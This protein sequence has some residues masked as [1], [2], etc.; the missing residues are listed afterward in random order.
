MKFT[1]QHGK[2]FNFELDQ[3]KVEWRPSA[4]GVVLNNQGQVLMLKTDYSDKW[5]FPGGMAEI[6]ETIDQAI[7]REFGEEIG[8]KVDP[9]EKELIYFRE[10]NFYDSYLDQHFHSIQLSFKVRLS[11]ATHYPELMLTGESSDAGEPHWVDIKD[12]SEEQVQH[13]HW[14]IIEKLKKL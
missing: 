10:N 8:Y 6:D 1:D 13:T 2:E 7:V 11:D 9:T 14:P 12:L 5:Q 3:I 4:Y